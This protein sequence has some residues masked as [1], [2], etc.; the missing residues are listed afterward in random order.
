MSKR[1]PPKPK[2]PRLDEEKVDRVVLMLV[3]LRSRG[4]VARQCLDHPDLMLTAKEATATIDEAASRIQLA[5]DYDRTH[6]LGQAITRLDELYARAVKA[7][8][9]KTA[10]AVQR[11][12]SKLTGLYNLDDEDNQPDQVADELIAELAATRDHLTPL[13]DSKPDDPLDEI[14]RRVVARFL[15]R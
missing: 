14:A 15:K 13:V 11:E 6:E 5:A 12:L 3:T 1:K 9:Y 2:P 7:Q 4:E 10:L 8:D